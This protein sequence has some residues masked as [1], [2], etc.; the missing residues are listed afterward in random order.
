M[1]WMQE[2]KKHENLTYLAL[3][4]MLFAVPVLSLYVRS[5]ND[6]SFSFQWGEVLMIWKQFAIYLAIFLLPLFPVG[7]SVGSTSN[8]APCISASSL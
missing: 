7:A 3:W 1:K 6:T 2:Q 8:V 5:V 4:G